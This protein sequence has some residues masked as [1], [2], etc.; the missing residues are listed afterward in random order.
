MGLKFVPVAEFLRLL[1]IRKYEKFAEDGETVTGTF[2][3][4]KFVDEATYESNEFMLPKEIDPASLK[5]QT[6]YKVILDMDG[7][8]TRLSLTPAEPAAPQMNI[9]NRTQQQ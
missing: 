1:D 7:R 5:V 6:R 2:H 4:V 8:W 9:K 3:F